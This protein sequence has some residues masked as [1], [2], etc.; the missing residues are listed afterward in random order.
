MLFTYHMQSTH[1]KRQWFARLIHIA[2]ITLLWG[3][4]TTPLPSKTGIATNENEANNLPTTPE[5][6]SSNQT[7]DQADE[8]ASNQPNEMGNH[9]TPDNNH[10]S[11]ND[12]NPPSH[13]NDSNTS[14]NHQHNDHSTENQTETISVVRSGNWS[15][16]SIWPNGIIPPADSRITIP[17]G[18]TLTVDGEIAHRYKLI[19]IDG[20]LQFATDINTLLTV[21]TIRSSMSGTLRV[22]TSTNPVKPNVRTRII[23]A[24]YGEIDRTEDPKELGRGAILMGKTEV[25]G[26]ERTSWLALENPPKRGDTVLHLSKPVVGWQVGDDL[27]V[28]GTDPMDPS[29]DE[30]VKIASMDE[31]TVTLESSLQRDH[32]PALS[33]LKVHV[34][35]TT[36]NIRFSS[37]NAAVK[38]RGHIMFMHTLDVDVNYA[39]F[40]RLGRTDK[41]VPIDDYYFPDLVEDLTTAYQGP[42]TNMRGRYSI[43]FHRGGNDSSLPPARVRGCAVVDNPGWA[44]VNHSSNVD[45]IENVSYKVVG[46]AFQTEAGD[47]VGSFINNIAIRTVNP[48]FPL[49][50]GAEEVLDIRE[51]AQDFSFQGDGFWIHGGGPKL[52]GNVVSGASG[53][54]YIY[55]TEGLIEWNKGMRQ[56]PNANIPN[57]HLLNDQEPV[58]VWWVPVGSFKNNVGYSAVKGL[59]LYY[60]HASFMENERSEVQVTPAFRQELESTFEELTLWG[61]QLS[62]VDLNYAE[63][64][65]F[66][67]SRLVGSG[68]PGSIGIDANHFHLMNRYRFENIDIEGFEVGIDVPTQGYTTIEGGRYANKIDFRI[69]NPQMGPRNLFLNNTSFAESTITQRQA[70]IKMDPNFTL[71]A[72]IQNG[73]LNTDLTKATLFFL[74]PDRII[75]NFDGWARGLYFDQQTPDFV[76]MSATNAKV[77]ESPEGGEWDKEVPEEYVGKT[78]QELYEQYDML[79]GGAFIPRDAVALDYILG[80]KVGS[81]APTPTTVPE[82][83]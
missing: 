21:E 23:F 78:N 71:K 18:V 13:N 80:G 32:T 33:D 3:C 5:K 72:E 67:N 35:N 43:H 30:V 44:Y 62:A 81:I 6:P 74:M 36:R 56:M 53:H 73:L 31:M 54:A 83:N 70:K 22:G 12:N 28:A 42:G 48:N 64:V 16:S 63:H 38:R 61:I 57:G 25:Y 40:Y 11:S 52:E 46:G 68:L 59:S 65:T 29:S 2:L 45:F 9:S 51:N 39:G 8:S 47:E 15:D 37:E 26:A 55:W 10:D 66:K 76:P 75:L 34:A 14:H 50:G 60:L 77:F 19:Q 41:S 7:T 20:T 49:L 27:V 69:R 17:Q 4:G 82:V 79:F 24:D 58:D 1:E